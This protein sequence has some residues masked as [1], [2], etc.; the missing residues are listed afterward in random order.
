MTKTYSVNGQGFNDY[1]AAIKVA[2]LEK[3][4]VIQNDNGL[5]RWEPIQPKIK[6]TIK[7]VL[8]NADGTFTEFSKVRR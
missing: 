5:V 6:K 4:Q 8:K 2:Q 3:A 1:F 7:H